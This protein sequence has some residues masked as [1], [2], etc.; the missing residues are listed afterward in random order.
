MSDSRMRIWFALFVLA[1]FC[2][3]LT[4]GMLIGRRMVGPMLPWGPEPGMFGGRGSGPG[5]G[6]G[7]GPSPERLVERLTTDLQLTPDQRLH[8]ENVLRSRRER[9]NQLQRDVHDRFEREQEELRAEIRK[10]LTPEQQ[11]K[12][13]RLIQEA[14]QRGPGRRDRGLPPPGGPPRP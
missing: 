12:Y 2:V 13:D 8:I 6:R 10:V 5:A 9:L 14:P 3:G 1:V 7:R 11:Q 4:A